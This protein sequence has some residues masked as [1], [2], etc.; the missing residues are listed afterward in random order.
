MLKNILISFLLWLGGLSFF[1]DDSREMYGSFAQF[2]ADH[3]LTI[4]SYGVLGSM[5]FIGLSYIFR[6]IGLFSLMFF[7][8]K[9]FFWL[10][11]FVISLISVV[12]V[13]FWFDWGRNL[14]LDL[15]YYVAA[16]PF[17]TLAAAAVN[18]QLFD[19]N[20]PVA[21]DLRN[22]IGLPIISGLIIWASTF[23]LG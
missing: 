9:L 18:L 5:S 4:L 12:A 15:G 13:A 14:W 17:V 23:I 2:V 10:S 8:N 1:G 6:G 19:F 11:Q 21:Q 20:F 3:D 22:H 16:V 7:L